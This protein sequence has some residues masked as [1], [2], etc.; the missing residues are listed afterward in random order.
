MA[1]TVS[2]I[3]P[4]LN[5]AVL[6]PALLDALR[7]QTHTPEEIIVADAGSSDDTVEIARRTGCR[8]VLGGRPAVGRNAGAEVARGD[9]LLFLDADV[10]PPPYFLACTLSEFEKRRL[11]V[12]TCR[13]WPYDGKSVDSYLHE[14][15]NWYIRML[16]PFSPHAPGFCL[17]SRRWAHKAAEGFDETL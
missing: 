6:L 8:V 16:R 5:E 9:V 14:I 13:S 12:A 15:A 17:F 10:L 4:T 7:A 3:I 11:V 1:S 2:I